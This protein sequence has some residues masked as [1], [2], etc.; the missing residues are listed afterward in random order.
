MVSVSSHDFGNVPFVPA[1]VGRLGQNE[2]G[3]RTRAQP[4][5]KR[6]PL[7]AAQTQAPM[8]PAS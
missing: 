1:G 4:P 8:P 5:G 6:L 3:S 2:I 7:K